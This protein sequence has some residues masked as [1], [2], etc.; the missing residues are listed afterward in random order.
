MKRNIIKIIAIYF[1]ATA[2]YASASSILAPFQGGTGTST[3][4]TLGQI[5]VGQ[6]N[7]T[8]GPQATSTLGISGGGSGTV[9]SVALTTPTGLSISGS[10]ITTSGTLGLTLTAGYV[11]PLSASTT[12]WKTAF[13]DLVSSWTA[14]LSFTSGVVSFDFT[15]ANTW[16]GQ[17][18]FN[19][20][21]PIF[22]TITGTTS[23]LHVNSAGLVS[24]TGAECGNGGGATLPGGAN[25]QLQ[26]NSGGVFAGTSTPTVAAI[27]ATTTAT[28]TFVGD[29]VSRCF[30]TSTNGPCLSSG[31]SFS[32]SGGTTGQNVYWTS[33]TTIGSQA[34]SSA[35]CS[36]G[37]SCNAFTVL[38]N[39]NPSFTNS[40]VTSI[41][42]L[43]G[44]VATSS[45]GITATISSST[46]AGS[47]PILEIGKHEQVFISTGLFTVPNGITKVLVEVQGGGGAGGTGDGSLHAAGGGGA[48]GY[49]RKMVDVSATTSVSVTIASCGV[50]SFSS[51]A[52]STAG[53]NGGGAG[54]AGGAPGLG[55]GGDL[56]LYGQGGDPG[57]SVSGVGGGTGG[58]GFFSGG[59]QGGLGSTPGDGHNG[60]GGGGSSSNSVSG[61]ACSDGTVV[62]TW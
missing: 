12:Q 45:L 59:G 34:T 16:T 13:D 30:A 36:S 21:A 42:G 7:G 44:S 37:V 3:A 4:P 1:L 58:N 27:N 26:Y 41:G 31:N 22:G 20:I 55:K 32:L 2:S 8:Y 23:C 43:T 35:T 62:I 53:S 5:L 9:T 56:N 61:G 14:P 51:F 40:G 33:A 49:A 38:G 15:H 29:I 39:T 17:Q 28:S 46:L 18:T 11:I 50:A 6:S 47:T 25:G 60:G 10:P 57:S 19:T 24:G 52:S 48:G 54:S